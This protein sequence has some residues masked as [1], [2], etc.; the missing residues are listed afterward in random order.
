MYICTYM[1]VYGIRYIISI[2]NHIKIISMH[3]LFIQSQLIH[4]TQFVNLALKLK[5]ASLCCWFTYPNL[6]PF[7]FR[8]RSPQNINKIQAK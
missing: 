1:Y 4:I 5:N 6:P 3:L 8:A 2:F 7:L